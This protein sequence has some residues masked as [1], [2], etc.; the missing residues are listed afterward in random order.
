VEEED[1][2]CHRTEGRNV[3]WAVGDRERVEDSSHRILGDDRRVVED[4]E[5]NL[6]IGRN[7]LSRDKKA[8]HSI[9]CLVEDNLDVLVVETVDIRDTEGNDLIGGARAEFYNNH[10][11]EEVDNLSVVE[12][13]SENMD[14]GDLYVAVDTAEGAEILLVGLPAAEKVNTLSYAQ[15][16][17][18]SETGVENS[19]TPHDQY[20]SS[21]SYT[22][23][24]ESSA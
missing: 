7:L 23:L 19:C 8:V 21:L 14:L 4:R 17:N 5:E 9:L 22:L 11:D 15:K 18:S 13:H 12:A 6:D 2:P 20:P 3:A 1:I 16:N 24:R 10:L